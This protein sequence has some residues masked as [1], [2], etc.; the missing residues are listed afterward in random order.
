MSVTIRVDTGSVV[1]T[2]VVRGMALPSGLTVHE[3]PD[4]WGGVVDGSWSIAHTRSGLNL[5]Y[6]LS[7][8]ETAAMVADQVAGLADWTV[9]GATLRAQTGLSAAAAVIAADV[10]ARSS[11]VRATDLSDIVATS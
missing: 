4:G 5:M 1:A 3:S 7:D 11:S 6:G 8:P 10:G 2:Q 9:D